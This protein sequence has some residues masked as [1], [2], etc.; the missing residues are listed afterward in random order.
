MSPL[1][2][3]DV[4]ALGWTLL[5]FVWQGAALA[6]L[7]ASLNLLLRHAAPQ[8]RYGLASAALLLMLLLPVLT[9]GLV[10]PERR[11]ATRAA[12]AAGWTARMAD[13]G[14]PYPSPGASSPIPASVSP[15]RVERLLPTFVAFWGAGVLLL[16]LRALGGWVLVQRLGRLGLASPPPRL[17]ETLD[18]LARALRVPVAVRL[19]ESALV[20]VPTVIGW[21]RPIVL[22]PASAIT[23]LSPEQLELIL[24]HELA[25]VRRFDYLANLVQTA[26][27]TLLFYHPAVWWVSRRMRVE[28]EHC[29]DDLAVAACGNPVRYARALADLQGLCAETPPVAM[30]ASGG[31]LWERVSR[32]VGPPPH[33]SRSSRGLAALLSG[34]GA[35]LAIGVA[36]TFVSGAPSWPAATASALPAAGWV[37]PPESPESPEPPEFLEP[38]EPPEPPEPLEPPE[39]PSPVE[40]AAAPAPPL[41][42]P[43]P[44]APVAPMAPPAPPEPVA[45]ATPADPAPPAPEP[46]HGTQPAAAPRPAPKPRPEPSPEPRA[47]PL[48]QVL[49][50]ARAGVTPDYLDAMDALGYSSLTAD[51]LVALR[52]HGV[53]PD[54]V[55]D[56]AAAGFEGLTAGQLTAL[57]SQGV[58]AAY[59]EGLKAEGL[60]RLST[61]DL[62]V[63]RAQGISAEFVKGL[64]AAGYADLSVPRLVALRQQGVSAAYV[65][66]LK[67]LGYDGLSVTRLI[68]LRSMGVTPEYVRALADLGYRGLEVTAL[69]ALRNQGVTPEF[70]RGLRDAGYPDLPAVAL[71]DL[72]AHGVTPELVR[73]LKDAGFG[74]L[75][76]EE[77]IELHDR[78]VSRRLLGRFRSRR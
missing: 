28:R 51:Q 49:E 21:L 46:T 2:P 63:L 3:Q 5:H 40:P 64:T 27:E 65:A 35:A 11:P 36:A 45:A 77:L 44:P 24:A 23:G 56:L 66:G 29:C 37:G 18:R 67:A 1:T 76:P 75:T 20:Q 39:P 41:A 70:A 59:A 32:I 8:A 15:A 10:R 16:S 4:Q 48:E 6:A 19:Y 13:A 57:R 55:R 52:R 54:F 14:A 42:P 43:G 38:S 71:I 61:S 60:D 31:S 7:V 72:R 9:F 30:A 73:E 58:S 25:H 47:F 12:G 33:P 17:E 26:A 68:A 50:L 34:A 74:G 78:G 69:I 22:V 53:G 62:L